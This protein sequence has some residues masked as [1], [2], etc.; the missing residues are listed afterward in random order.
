M[1]VS[2]FTRRKILKTTNTL[3]LIP[4]ALVK[5]ET[6]ENGKIKLII[7]RFSSKI[8]AQIFTGKKKSTQF[9]ISLDE[10]GSN[11]WL[12]IDGEKSVSEIITELIPILISKNLSIE[13]IEER[14]SAFISR[15]YQEEY[16]T[17]KQLQ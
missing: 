4:I 2:Y 15:L 1:P 16:I 3:D 9:R 14:V 5:H 8:L 11:V 7:P 6:L 17:F 10:T 12:C 13:V